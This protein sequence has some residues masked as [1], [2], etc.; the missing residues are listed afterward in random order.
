M[1]D[2]GRADGNRTES[3][4][5]RPDTRGDR[6][7]PARRRTAHH[8]RLFGSRAHS[9]LASPDR[10]CY[11]PRRAESRD[12]DQLPTGVTV[13][14]DLVRLNDSIEGKRLELDHQL[15]FF[16]QLGRLGK[17]LHGLAIFP[18]AGDSG[19]GCGGAEIGN[20]DNLRRLRSEAD[21]VFN[22]C[23]ADRVEDGVDLETER[24]YSIHHAFA[25][26]HRDSADLAEVVL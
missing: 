22:G 25:V 14:A 12:K 23:L 20:G 10:S 1:G 6:G 13:V 18:T 2:D 4:L 19:A 21:Q 7:L 26:D 9:Q 15:A 3:N 24:T 17:S 8:S 11:R 5:V 16:Q